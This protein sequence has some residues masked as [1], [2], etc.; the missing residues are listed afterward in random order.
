MPLSRPATYV[1]RISAGFVRY[2][3]DNR[4]TPRDRRGTCALGDDS[5]HLEDL[6]VLTVDVDAVSTRDVPDIFGI[7]VAAVVLRRERGDRGVAARPAISR[8][9][10][11][12]PAAVDRSATDPR[13][14]PTGSRKDD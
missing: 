6:R 14:H 10:A 1:V 13:S 8:V 2:R 4:E 5:I 7:R 12:Q 11:A 3:P 9:A